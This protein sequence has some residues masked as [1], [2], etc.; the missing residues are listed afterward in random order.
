MYWQC[1]SCLLV[2]VD[3]RFWL[4]PDAEKAE[5]DLHENHVDD[6]GYQNFLNRLAQ[7][8]LASIDLPA[9]GLDFGCGPGP[10]LQIMLERA[11]CSVD[12][13]D[14]FY[15]PDTAVFQRRYDFIT[16][17]EVVEHLHQPRFELDRLWA[18]LKSGGC[19]ALMTKRVKSQ[20]AFARWH[21]KNDLTH[22][23]F[24]S[25]QTFQWLAGCWQAQVFFPAADVVFFQKS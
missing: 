5:Y 7:P 8:L 4:S 22:V 1:Q 10:A 23:C 14:I 15:A 2:F 18:L 13:Y 24:F 17:T 9:A 25:E 21:Y 12:V 11:G 16:A 20:E 3:K 19:L 6:P